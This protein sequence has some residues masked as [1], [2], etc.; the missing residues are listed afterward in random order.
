MQVTVAY[1]AAASA[2][3]ECGRNIGAVP[4]GVVIGARVVA[5]VLGD[6]SALGAITTTWAYT[7]GGWWASCVTGAFYAVAGLVVWGFATA[8][9]RGRQPV[10]VPDLRAR[11][12]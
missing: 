2:P 1:V 5:G 3:G 10:K 12:N 7:S 4:S 8:G 6:T 9:T 11:T